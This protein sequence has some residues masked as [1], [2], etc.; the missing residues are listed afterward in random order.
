MSDFMLNSFFMT[1]SVGGFG[2]K[3]TNPSTGV[4]TTSKN[5]SW[6]PSDAAMAITSNSNIH[7]YPWSAG[8]GTK[9]AAPASGLGATNGTPLWKSTETDMV[10]STSVTP[11]INAYAW[12]A[13]FGTKYANPSTLPTSSCAHGDWISDDTSV[14]AASNNTPYVHVYTWSSGFSTKYANPRSIIPGATPALSQPGVAIHPN[15]NNIGFGYSGGAG[16]IVYKW[17]NGFEA[18]YKDINAGLGSAGGYG[19]NWSNNGDVVGMG[20]NVTS[21]PFAWAW[22]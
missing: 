6:S 5:L 7:A 9:Y 19:F 21:T 4:G 22:S 14:A 18:Q 20:T 11:F 12:S 2:T 17:N 8:F 15:D 16:Y 1:I 3:Y 13:G 10:V